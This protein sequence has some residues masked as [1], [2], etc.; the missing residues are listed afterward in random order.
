MFHGQHGEQ[1]CSSLP[2]PQPPERK[3]YHIHFVVMEHGLLG[4]HKNLQYFEE[5][6]E[7]EIRRQAKRARERRYGSARKWQ[8][9]S[10]ANNTSVASWNDVKGTKETFSGVRE[11]RRKNGFPMEN[12]IEKTSVAEFSPPSCFSA[13]SSSTPVLSNRALCNMNSWK[14][15]GG[16]PRGQTVMNPT[17][18]PPRFRRYSQEKDSDNGEEEEE[19][20]DIAILILNHPGNDKYRC[21]SGIQHCAHRLTQYVLKNVE[22]SVAAH[23]KKKED[24][25]RSQ[26]EKKVTQWKREQEERRREINRNGNDS[27][28]Y[29]Q[30]PLGSFSP[31]SVS[32][33]EYSFPSFS[34]YEGYPHR[35]TY[36]NGVGSEGSHFGCSNE[37]EGGDVSSVPYHMMDILLST[38]DTVSVDV[39]TKKGENGVREISCSLKRRKKRFSNS[40]SRRFE[41]IHEEKVRT[42]IRRKVNHNHER[43]FDPPNSFSSFWLSSLM[44][45]EG[46]TTPLPSA[47]PLTVV[48]WN[49]VFHWVGYSLGGL[50]IRAALPQIMKGVMDCFPKS[51]EA[52]SS[53]TPGGLGGVSPCQKVVQTPPPREVE[54]EETQSE[55]NADQTSVADD[56]KQVLSFQHKFDVVSEHFFSLCCPHLG[57]RP[58]HPGVKHSYRLVNCL[59]R[60]C[61]LP[62]VFRDLLLKS[63]DIDNILLSP[64]Y[65][66]ALAACREKVFILLNNDRMVWNCSG[67]LTL[68]PLE[69]L[70]LDGYSI[71]DPIV[72]VKLL[73]RS[74]QEWQAPSLNKMS[75]LDSRSEKELPRGGQE[76]K[77]QVEVQEEDAKKEER[78]TYINPLRPSLSEK[79]AAFS[80]SFPP[81]LPSSSTSSLCFAPWLTSSSKEAEE[82]RFCQ[83]S[84]W[85]SLGVYPATN[86]EE[87][88]KNGIWISQERHPLEA[89]VHDDKSNRKQSRRKKEDEPKDDERYSKE[90]GNAA[91]PTSTESQRSSSCRVPYAY[92][93]GKVYHTQ[94]INPITWPEQYLPRE[95]EMAQVFLQGI[96]RVELHVVDFDQT[97]TRYLGEYI[98]LMPSVKRK[99]K[100][101]ETTEEYVGDSCGLLPS[102]SS[103]DTARKEEENQD[104][105]GV[106]R[107]SRSKT[108]T[109]SP[110][111]CSQSI[112]ELIYTTTTSAHQLVV[113]PSSEKWG[114]RKKKERKNMQ[115]R[116]SNAK[117]SADDCRPESRV[118]SPGL[119]IS[120]LD[121]NSSMGSMSAEVSTVKVPI[122][123]ESRSASQKS[124]P[125]LNPSLPKDQEETG[126]EFSS[127]NPFSFTIEYIVSRIAD[128]IFAENRAS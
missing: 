84:F 54:K 17:S 99:R 5:A 64:Q 119:S 68:P 124:L 44:P 13:R 37:D 33:H 27:F 97:V 102:S 52:G 23:V 63:D 86:L 65:L 14:H 42:R 114:E 81:P 94:W 43:Q 55:S 116:S 22:L 110:T 128:S 11:G 66:K 73:T 59:D 90:K 36:A 126:R 32:T 31:V 25:L 58:H 93:S 123:T 82:S 56:K 117:G 112:A 91:P 47:T 104:E 4:T 40:P 34:L 38:N 39:E 108:R 60:I 49:V 101:T 96:G 88:S 28:G 7:T 77:K 122:E 92:H 15:G 10:Y 125:A 109:A 18:S 103:P 69:R 72:D 67:G 121:V 107:W 29:C 120:L 80:S 70:S 19:E 46:S 74:F 21:F 20:E 127:G 41:R 35:K 57:T 50:I 71:K 8:S 62:R 9:F 51:S 83:Y 79:I 78:Q 106:E 89:K 76:A 100:S 75:K 118:S 98:S 1:R 53:V 87:I 48:R 61:L 2:R 24:A 12:K 45:S 111:K 105:Q 95:R 85:V 3:D 26:H 30:K 6:L 115:I 113:C 16:G